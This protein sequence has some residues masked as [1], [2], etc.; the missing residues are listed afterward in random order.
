M[1]PKRDAGL[2]QGKRLLVEQL[3]SREAASG[4]QP[5][6]VEQ[7]MLEQINDIRANPAA[8][9]A[10]IGVDLSNVAAAPPLAFD[11]VLIQAARLHAL[12]M[13]NQ[14]YVSR[15]SPQGLDPGARLTQLGFAWTSWLENSATGATLSD[16]V[17][18]VRSLVTNA[19]DS[20]LN[21]RDQLLGLDAFARA[22]TL[23]G[24]GIVQNVGGPQTNYYTVDTASIS[25]AK[26]YLVGVVYKDANNNGH[27]D[28][29]EGLAG[30]TITATTVTTTTSTSSAANSTTNTA[31]TG[32]TGSNSNGTSNS[33]T[34]AAS[35]P[36]TNPVTTSSSSTG[37][38]TAAASST[39]ASNSTTA[40]TA[41]APA[42]AS[43]TATSST[44]TSAAINTPASSST[45]T[46]PATST[47]AA[48]AP[49]TFTTTTFDSGGYSLQLD[50]GM[51]TVTASGGGL[52]APITQTVQVTNVN[53]RLTFVVPGDHPQ[54]PD[55]TW[56]QLLNH[57]LLGRPATPSEVDTVV[58]T[59]ATG[60]TTRAVVQN[61][62]QSKEFADNEVTS[63]YQHYL[64]R[65]PT[66]QE[67]VD[68]ASQLQSGTSTNKVRS[69]ILT[70]SEFSTLSGGTA[71]G[72]VVNLY[73]DLLGRTPTGNEADSWVSQ[74]SSGDLAGV[75]NGILGSV[76]FR[77]DLINNDY[78][79]FLRR[80]ADAPGRGF[81][82]NELGSNND[83]TTIFQQFLTS[84][85]YRSNA[86]DVLWLRRLYQDVLGRNGDR[87]NEL[88]FWLAMVHNGT[89][90]ATIASEILTSVEPHTDTVTRL[91][92]ELLARA[93]DPSGASFSLHLLQTDGRVAEL[94]ADIVGSP[95]YFGLHGSDN[96]KWVQTLY[97]NLLGRAGTDTEVQNWLKSLNSGTSR[98]AVASQFTSSTA[99]LQEFVRQQYN[100][101]L[102]RAPTVA[103][104]DAAVTQLQSHSTDADVVA[105]LLTS[106]EYT[107]ASVNY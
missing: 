97:Q 73:Q 12:D 82:V 30:V 91:Y 104:R 25:S 88:G 41:T 71:S 32:T 99:Y 76:E 38:T 70:S 75:V 47:T 22:Q 24:I 8:F 23:V 3:E 64:N 14:G 96:T 40:N 36:A 86:A 92:H 4:L 60:G 89:S 20:T 74:A 90:H 29:N 77:T 54:S 27:Y 52:T 45:A 13:N 85:E 67:L 79:A 48:S 95:E 57:D 101:Y 51:Y 50:P 72:F 21:A 66:S 53:T 94:V 61:I 62:E 107:K 46:T 105:Q 83:Q 42:G 39:A 9:G 49:S 65:A 15:I 1:K 2:P 7:Y 37:T 55:A 103:E 100:R 11:P 28:I 5:T 80:G 44:T 26:P 17:S 31:A 16:T 33:T 87:P 69:Q 43:T 6:A 19:N 18:A 84:P 63:W 35:T 10:A 59:L 106:D 58:Q 56:A 102:R 81:Y 98:A 93:P 34:S 78:G 68:A